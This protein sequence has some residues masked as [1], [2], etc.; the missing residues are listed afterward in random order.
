MKRSLHSVIFFLLLV[1]T[2]SFAQITSAASGNWSAGATWTGGV[3][4]TA[5]DNVVISDGNT[6]T[7]DNSFECANLTVGGG[8]SGKLR[9][10]TTVV[11][12]L[13]VHGNVLVN[14][15][16]TFA[17]Q[18]SATGTGSIV[19]TCIV[20][21]DFTFNS[22][23][24]KSFNQRSG[25]S[26][27]VP[28]TVGVINFT[29]AGSKNSTISGAF[30]LQDNAFNSFTINK[31]G[32]AK[33]ILGSNVFMLNG[34]SADPASDAVLTF[35]NGVIETGSYT[36][37]QAKT[38]P[39]VNCLGASNSSYVLGSFGSGLSATNKS[40]PVGDASGY[41]PISVKSTTVSGGSSAAGYHY[42]VVSD[43]SANA[44][45]GSS[46]LSA[47]IDKV[48]A[49]RY[50]KITYNRGN[51]TPNVPSMSF[52]QFRPSYGSSD[53]VAAGNT[54]LRVAYS[55]DGRATWTGISQSN[56]HTT[57]LSAP[58]TI[59]IPDTLTASVTLDSSNACYVA[60]ARV[61]GT[62]ENSLVGTLTVEKEPGIAKSFNLSQNY[63]NPFN[64]STSISFS[65]PSSDVVTLKVY[66]AIGKEVASLVNEQKAAGNY[67]VSF[68]ASHLSSGV[69]FYRLATTHS[70]INKKMLLLK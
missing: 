69:Y 5:T 1:S 68:D 27:A 58:P 23:V 64:P 20:Y 30:T 18:N 14:S 25:S 62:T 29:F 54:N 63:P 19:H 56:S 41:H 61:A 7:I 39:G 48:S 6:V 8:V 10:S 2:T 44:N 53:G 17:P 3:V 66:D 57:D 37:I 28:P 52:N 51:T 15:G 55:T 40:F 47:D 9:T 4:P 70:V 50:Y 35:V 49:A 65:I 34:S 24:A 32:S 11:C 38:N 45:T 26:S 59:F 67:K 21:G 13:T 46:V 33:V 42:V 31:T 36:F 12:T 16:A 22:L 43:V 60:F